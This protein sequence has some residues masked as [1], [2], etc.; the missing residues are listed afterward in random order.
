MQQVLRHNDAMAF[1]WVEKH[2][3]CT[4][5]SPS[6]TECVP[7]IDLS[8][9]QALFPRAPRVPT[10]VSLSLGH[11][12]PVGYGGP[13]HSPGIWFNA[14]KCFR[15]STCIHSEIGSDTDIVGCGMACRRRPTPVG[16]KCLSLT[17]RLQLDLYCN[18][19]VRGQTGAYTGWIDLRQRAVA[20]FR[21][22]DV[23]QS[24]NGHPTAARTT[25]RA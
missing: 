21:W 6:H 2:T 25:R 22:A 5:P 14:T 10:S 23:R 1:S 4:A 18:V 7:V 9:C 13:D 8:A 3:R 20:A 15:P 24:A 16:I 12:V 19:E 17:V 11:R